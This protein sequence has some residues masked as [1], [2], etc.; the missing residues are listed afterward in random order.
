MQTYTYFTHG[1]KDPLRFK[2]MVGRSLMLAMALPNA[3]SYRIDRVP[4]VIGISQ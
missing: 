3:V 1:S 4:L 2:L